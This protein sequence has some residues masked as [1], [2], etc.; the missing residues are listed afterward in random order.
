MRVCSLHCLSRTRSDKTCLFD[1]STSSNIGDQFE[2]PSAHTISAQTGRA[3]TR[4][5]DTVTPVVGPYD[6]AAIS[7]RQFR[8]SSLWTRVTKIAQAL[9][10]SAYASCGRIA[11]GRRRISS[12]RH[13]TLH[14]HAAAQQGQGR[15]E[16]R[17]SRSVFARVVEHFFALLPTTHG[18]QTRGPVRGV[19]RLASGSLPSRFLPSSCQ[20]AIRQ[21]KAS[22]ISLV[23]S[24]QTH[25]SFRR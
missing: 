1:L 5:R 21:T 4:A 3:R 8:R 2:L 11:S 15:G 16:R 19:T 12:T 17:R 18:R 20:S 9:P 13:S 10:R 14:E 6:L 22:F 25:P 24:R 7:P 23:E